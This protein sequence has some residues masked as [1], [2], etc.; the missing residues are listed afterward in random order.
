MCDIGYLINSKMS[1]Q[2]FLVCGDSI[3]ENNFETTVVSI[4]SFTEAMVRFAIQLFTQLLNICFRFWSLLLSHYTRISEYI[5]VFIFDQFH[6]LMLKDTDND[7]DQN[8]S[9]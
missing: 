6:D 8:D 3:N 9:S 1:A 5:F 2:D 4:H 7:Q